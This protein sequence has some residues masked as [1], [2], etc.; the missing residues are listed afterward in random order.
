MDNI[1]NT[2]TII[3]NGTMAKKESVKTPYSKVIF[4]IAG[5]LEKEGL[6][7]DFTVKEKGGKSCIIF[8]LEY[9]EDDSPALSVIERVS[10]PGK[11]VYVGYNDIPRVR[12]GF[13]MAILSTPKGVMG[14]SQA[15]REKVGGELLCIVY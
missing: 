5:V 4:G 8:T 15:K 7:K 6:I 1:A 10:K 11:R 12:S 2:L 9:N 14:S 3:R 13:G